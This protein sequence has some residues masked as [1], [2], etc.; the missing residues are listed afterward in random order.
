MATPETVMITPSLRH[1]KTALLTTT[2]GRQ[3]ASHRI[4]AS[5]VARIAVKK[6][7]RTK[8]TAKQ[9]DGL[10]AVSAA[11]YKQTIPDPLRF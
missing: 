2:N 10:E 7:R 4:P 8:K 6:L 5:I 3:A 9:G 11:N 1:K